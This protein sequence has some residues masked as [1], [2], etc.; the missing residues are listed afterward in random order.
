MYKSDLALAAKKDSETVVTARCMCPGD[1]DGAC[2]GVGAVL[3][4][5][6]LHQNHIMTEFKH[7]LM[8]QYHGLEEHIR[9]MNRC[10]HFS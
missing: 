3:H 2:R 7:E 5:L 6:E 8:F 9:V 1:T 4:E 10:R